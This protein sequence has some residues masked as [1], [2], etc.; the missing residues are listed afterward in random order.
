MIGRRRTEPQA[1][2]LP[3]KEGISTSCDCSRR[4]GLKMRMPV[5]FRWPPRPDVLQ[6]VEKSS[7][8]LSRGWRARASALGGGWHGLCERPTYVQR[9]CSGPAWRRQ[10]P[11]QRRGTRSTQFGSIRW[12]NFALHRRP[13]GP[14]GVLCVQSADV[15]AT[16]TS[17]FST[18]DPE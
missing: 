6:I 2:S 14:A 5:V 1:W 13:S 15:Y 8:E 17:H 18:V 3:P 9:L 16:A 10:Y 11:S 7:S 12:A 4:R